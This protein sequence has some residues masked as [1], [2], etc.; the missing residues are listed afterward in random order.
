MS[1]TCDLGFRKAL[2][3]PTE[4]RGRAGCGRRLSWLT[5]VLK[6]CV[7]RFWGFCAGRGADGHFAALR[8][9]CAA[10]STRNLCENQG[11]SGSWRRACGA[12]AKAGGRASLA[13]PRRARG[14]E[15]SRAPVARRDATRRDATEAS[16]GSRFG[17]VALEKPHS[18]AEGCDSARRGA[19]TINEKLLHPG[20]RGV[21][22]W[23]RLGLAA[24]RGAS[25]DF[26]FVFG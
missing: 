13:V 3:Y 16:N 14:G 7:V 10:R 25:R 20:A 24:A 12:G 18:D 26:E 6:R 4:L 23:P 2:L 22:H 9:I 5:A 1:R 8:P 17:C 11:A 21:G 15:R 19:A